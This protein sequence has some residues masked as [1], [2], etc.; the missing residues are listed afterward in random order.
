[1]QE[2]T[3]GQDVRIIDGPYEHFTGSIED[4]DLDQRKARVRVNLFGYP[5][6]AE[7]PLHQIE[8]LKP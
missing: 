6:P 5:T 1:M 2:L 3:A 7:L 4:V 8:A